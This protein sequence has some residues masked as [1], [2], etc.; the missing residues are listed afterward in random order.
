M[1]NCFIQPKSIKESVIQHEAP[2]STLQQQDTSPPKLQEHIVE[3]DAVLINFFH[4]SGFTET[5][6]DYGTLTRL[7]HISNTD[8]CCVVCEEDYLSG[9]L[10]AILRCNHYLHERCYQRMLEFGHSCCAICR[11]AFAQ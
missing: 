4:E 9:D 5:I 7:R 10:L 2:P 3:P 1:G 11:T 6:I 8:H